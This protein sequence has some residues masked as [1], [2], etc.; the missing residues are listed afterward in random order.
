M[1]G[2]TDGCPV[3]EFETHR[4]TDGTTSIR[5]R[6]GVSAPHDMQPTPPVPCKFAVGDRVIYTND[7]GAEFTK[8][9]R[10]FS[11]T[12]QSLYKYGRFVYLDMDCWWMPVS[13][14]RL[15]LLS[16]NPSADAAAM[17]P[18]ENIDRPN[19]RWVLLSVSEPG[20]DL[21]KEDFARRG[22]AGTG[23]IRRERGSRQYVAM[24]SLDH[25]RASVIC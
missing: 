22:W 6:H 8:T 17:P 14:S 21:A 3:G 23:L 18:I 13:P 10:G 25:K 12:E 24:I 20:H 7:Y 1:N 19:E 4:S 11:G 15:K 16:A 9:V 2:C 5:V